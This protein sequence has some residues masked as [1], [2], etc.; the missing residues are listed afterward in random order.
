MD[1]SE[2]QPHEVQ[3]G[4][5]PEHLRT[6]AQWIAEARRSALAPDSF[7]PEKGD[8]GQTVGFTA[9]TRQGTRIIQELNS[10]LHPWLRVVSQ[11]PELVITINHVP[12]RICRDEGDLRP[13]SKYQHLHVQEKV[14]Q[15][16][17][18]FGDPRILPADVCWRV[19]Y[20]TDDTYELKEIV[21][22]QLDIHQQKVLYS[23]PIPFAQEGG[24]STLSLPG[25]APTALRVPYIGEKSINQEENTA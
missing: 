20:R 23:W 5:D 22:V 2:P 4:L 12:L 19:L 24:P 3:P 9:F 1:D 6:L 16:Q 18:E 25:S 13:K 10:G 21:L 14:V 15:G 8:N 7:H 17:L 11:M